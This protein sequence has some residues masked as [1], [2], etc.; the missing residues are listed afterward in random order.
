MDFLFEE[1]NSLKTVDLSNFNTE[2]VE[3]M[4]EVFL[5]CNNLTYIDI[6]NFSN[7]TIN[8][9]NLFEGVA[10]NGTIKINKDIE[11]RLNISDSWT[12]IY[13]DSRKLFKN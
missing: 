10:P 12:I 5:N 4:T 9:I 6:S 8:F 3:N 2:K 1:C 7:N 11:N 13:S